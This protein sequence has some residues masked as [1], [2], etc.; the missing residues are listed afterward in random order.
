MGTVRATIET[1]PRRIGSKRGTSLSA[2]TTPT[3]DPAPNAAK[4]R[5]ATVELRSKSSYPRTGSDADSICPNMFRNSAV[6]DS[7]RSS[8]SRKRKRIP[9][10]RPRESSLS[11]TGGRRGDEAPEREDAHEQE[12]EREQAGL[13]QERDREHQRRAAGVA[14]H[15]RRARSELRDQCPAR[16]PE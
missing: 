11:A 13:V 7:R 3:S 2:S 6:T 14:E 16:N 4:K 8:G 9:A 10:S 15:H 1:A 12:R 5:P